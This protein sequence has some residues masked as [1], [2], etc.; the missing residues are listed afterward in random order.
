MRPRTFFLF[1]VGVALITLG[2]G[3]KNPTGSD[4]APTP[5]VLLKT[6]PVQLTEVEIA[7]EMVQLVGVLGGAANFTSK[8]P[9][10]I[11]LDLTGNPTSLGDFNVLA[12]TY[13]T[14]KIKVH[15]LPDSGNSQ[16]TQFSVRIQGTVDDNSAAVP[17]TF[18]GDVTTVLEEEFLDPLTFL[19]SSANLVSRVAM[20]VDLSGWFLDKQGGF[21]DPR[22]PNNQ[23]PI[24]K[25]I[26]NS[27]RDS[28]VAAAGQLFNGIAAAFTSDPQIPAL[29]VQ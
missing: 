12:G 24:E 20:L 19:D 4:V 23:K 2:C 27:I 18:E 5:T 16:F 21:L 14:L 7:V 11:N 8:Q 10:I 6:G 13:D 17:F 29:A 28:G 26:K 22:D 25:N 15:K 1:T 9:L 3:Q